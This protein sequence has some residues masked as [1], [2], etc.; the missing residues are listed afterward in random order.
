ME[1]FALS[2]FLDKIKEESIKLKAMP[3]KEKKLSFIIDFLKDKDDLTYLEVG[4]GVGY[5]FLSLLSSLKIKRAFLIEKDP[6]RCEKLKKNIEVFLKNNK[7]S[8]EIKIFCDDALKV[9]PKILKDKAFD[10]CL[11]DANKSK[12]L[13]YYLL[14]RKKVRFLFFDNTFFFPEGKRYNT[15]RRKLKEFHEK[16]LFD[17][18]KQ[19]IHYKVYDGISLIIFDL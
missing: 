8:V 12:Y 2:D 1:K 4:S 7:K 18:N 15:I 11:V 17:D 19:V 6:I 9:I 13:D 3:L 14:L 16:V 5:S 10:F